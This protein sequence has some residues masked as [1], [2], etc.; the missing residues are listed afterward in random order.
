MAE[1]N[2]EK[3]GEI[4]EKLRQ[5]TTKIENNCNKAPLMEYNIGKD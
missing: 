3:F 2:L 1:T 5:K 4:W